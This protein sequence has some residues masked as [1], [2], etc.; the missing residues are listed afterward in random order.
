[1]HRETPAELRNSFLNKNFRVRALLLLRESRT[2]PRPS[3]AQ[4]VHA[5][6]AHSSVSCRFKCCIW[7]EKRSLRRSGRGVWHACGQAENARGNRFVGAGGRRRNG[8]LV[9][10]TGGFWRFAILRCGSGGSGLDSGGDG[11]PSRV[12]FAG[13]AAAFSNR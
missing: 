7:R 13:G 12:S 8:N 6:T 10:C 4:L 3:T 1:G 2:M 11:D 5:S 9:G